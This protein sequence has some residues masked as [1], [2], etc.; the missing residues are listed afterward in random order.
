L[1]RNRSEEKSLSIGE[2]KLDVLGRSEGNK[3]AERGS[4]NQD[5]FYIPEKEDISKGGILLVVADGVGGSEAGGEASGLA[6]KKIKEYYYGKMS[7]LPP[8]PQNAKKSLEESVEKA[9]QAIL[10]EKS[11]KGF[12]SM[13]TTLVCVVLLPPTNSSDQYVKVMFANVGDSRGYSL[14]KTITLMTEDTTWQEGEVTGPMVLG[15]NNGYGELKY[16]KIFSLGSQETFLLCTDGLSDFVSPEEMQDILTTPGHNLPAAGDELMRRV[17]EQ[18]RL[19]D[20]TFII[21][22]VKSDNDLPAWLVRLMIALVVLLVLGLVVISGFAWLS[23]SNEPTQEPTATPIAAITSTPTTGEG[24]GG[25]NITVPTATSNNIVG[26]YPTATPTPLP[27]DTPT[28]IPSATPT[29]TATPLPPTSGRPSSAP[30]K[31]LATGKGS[32]PSNSQACLYP[33]PVLIQDVE[34]VTIAEGNRHSF[35]W[36]WPNKLKDN[37]SFELRIWTDGQDVHYGAYDAK[38]IPTFLGDGSYELSF[39]PSG[40]YGVKTGGLNKPYY[41][42]VA[43]VQLQPFRDLSVEADPRMINITGVGPTRKPGDTG[44]SGGIGQ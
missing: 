19:D 32:C 33:A 23:A 22:R 13:A 16:S 34:M 29:N 17:D 2:R 15:N 21:C 43:V 7:K 25:N 24:Q 31:P 8:T 4:N 28:P 14:R 1:S 42:T 18:G 5:Y 37:E 20:T 40:A 30:T 27:T 6:V 36:R 12:D 35:R 3:N 38:E 9:Q 11:Q 10:N 39:A 44:S 26:G 41:W